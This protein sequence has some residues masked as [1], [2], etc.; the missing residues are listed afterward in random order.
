MYKVHLFQY[1][2][3]FNNVFNVNPGNQGP[4]SFCEV[5]RTIGYGNSEPKSSV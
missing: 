2:S 3:Q 4:Q 5:F 1:K